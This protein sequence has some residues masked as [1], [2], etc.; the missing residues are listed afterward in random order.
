MNENRRYFQ[1]IV[2]DKKGEVVE[3]DKIE[4]EEGNV[5]I[6]FKDKS[7]INEQFVA[8]LNQ[9]DL[10]GKLMAE[11]DSPTNIWK[12]QTEIIGGE[13]ERIEQDVNS[14]V[15]YEVPSADE[16]AHAD[17]T[18]ETGV[19][20]P[21]VKRKKVT[22]IPPRPTAPRSSNFGVISSPPP[23][24][25]YIEVEKSKPK[26]DESDPVYILMSKSK[27]IDT[28]ILMNITVS[29]PPKNLYNIAKESF[30]QGNKSFVRYII[31]DITVDEIKEALKIAIT[32]MY[33]ETDKE[34]YTNTGNSITG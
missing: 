22:L 23:E 9:R 11:V 15:R 25:I 18:G 31:E 6:V 3:F 19:T 7:R 12:F 13:S 10:S 27:K 29:L 16:I 26:I 1:W 32:E 30:D 17:L 5:F 21:I 14:G 33:E 34:K 2:A 4:Y 8:Q 20:K 24:P 28:E